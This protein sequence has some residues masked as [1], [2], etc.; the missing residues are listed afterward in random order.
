[1]YPTILVPIED[2]IHSERV[3]PYA[4]RLAAAGHGR[5]ELLQVIC[6]PELRQHAESVI[7]RIAERPVAV[8]EV[9]NSA[10]EQSPLLIV[11]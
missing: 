1:M 5:L 9:V 4:A 10:P 11:G 3:L 7:G 8:R 6:D 2:S